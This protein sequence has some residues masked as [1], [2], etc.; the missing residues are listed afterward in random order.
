MNRDT[1]SDRAAVERWEDEGGRALRS[2]DE[3]SL[4]LGMP[5]HDGG[6]FDRSGRR[7]A[8]S[9]RADTRSRRSV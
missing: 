1:A 7:P 9:R 4:S 3:A 8:I 5:R 6:A 2:H